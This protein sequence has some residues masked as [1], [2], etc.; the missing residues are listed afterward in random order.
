MMSMRS[1]LSLGM[2]LWDLFQAA[3][4]ARTIDSIA[5]TLIN[6]QDS[7]DAPDQNSTSRCGAVQ[8]IGKGE[9]LYN[10]TVYFQVP[11]LHLRR[12]N[13]TPQ[14]TTIFLAIDSE[15]CNSS[16]KFGVNSV[17][18]QD[19][20]QAGQPQVHEFFYHW[21]PAQ[22]KTVLPDFPLHPGDYI[23]L[24]I[25]PYGDTLLLT[26]TND[27]YNRSQIFSLQEAGDLCL[28]DFAVMIQ[29]PSLDPSEIPSVNSTVALNP[30]VAL[31]DFGAVSWM[32][33][34]GLT[35]DDK[36]YGIYDAKMT[37]MKNE[38]TGLYRVVAF[39]RGDDEHGLIMAGQNYEPADE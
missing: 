5:N 16:F 2:A 28:S 17:I 22:P 11:T 39:Q 8:T 4:A 6:R 33:V 36:D 3:T 10:V 24:Q 29:D 19:E 35:A 37:Y 15:G 38:K 13:P 26:I 25:F 23:N 18:Y 31:A 14:G 30:P 12:N 21:A 32:Y 34:G 20:T 7:P 9:R 1:F 27:A